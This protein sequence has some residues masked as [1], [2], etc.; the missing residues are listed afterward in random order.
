MKRPSLIEDRN[1]AQNSAFLCTE[2]ENIEVLKMLGIDAVT[3]ANNHMFDYGSE[4]YET[5]KKLLEET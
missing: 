4:G 1:T 2:P 5:T 3:L